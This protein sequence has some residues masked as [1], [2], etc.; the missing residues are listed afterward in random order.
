MLFYAFKS[1]FNIN[2][3]RK[4]HQIYIL[5]KDFVLQKN[6]IVKIK[7]YLLLIA[8]YQSR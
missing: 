2:I 1:Q 4:W 5:G 3:L 6:C 7:I 8:Y